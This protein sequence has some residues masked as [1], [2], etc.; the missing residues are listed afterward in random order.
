MGEEEL[1]MTDWSS[2]DNKLLDSSWYTTTEYHEVFKTLRDEDPIHWAQDEHY[3]RPYWV[4][5]RYDDV[6]DYLQNW[7]QLSSRWD[8]RVPKSPKRRTP[9]ER[10]AVGMDVSLARNDPP[11]HDLYRRPLN[12]HFSVPAINK[13]TQGVSDIVDECIADVAEKGE[14]DVV[15]TL[16]GELPVKV[17]LRWL[18]VPE[19][20]W[21]ML[22]EATWQWLAPADPNFVIDNDPV[23]TTLVGQTRLLEYCEELALERRRSPQDDF[24][25]V[26][27]NMTIDGDRL[28]PHEMRSYLTN[29]IGGGLETTRNAASV[30]LWQ[31]LLNPDQRA[32]LLADPSLA[33]SAVEEVVRWVTP[34]KNRLRVA[35]DGFEWRDKFINRGDWV[36][37]FQAS[38]NKD[39]RVFDDPH[40]F[41]ITRDPSLHI[42]FGE[43]V[44]MCL[45][46]ALARLELALFFPRV[47]AAFPD[48]EP[49]GDPTW[50]ADNVTTGFTQFPVTFTP[51]PVPAK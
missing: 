5:T 32:L 39:E 13:L 43:G 11:V 28:S 47:L 48:M 14:C 33:N 19:E 24:A 3:G 31:F 2:I 49:A 42:G 18:G 30:G 27:G 41:D 40:R 22:R 44:H 16:A 29:I 12:K 21:P 51:R 35:N 15:E 34:G 50:I 1:T 4:V 17:I 8:T 23:K 46:R 26:I 6:K 20:D 45:G 37:A 38:A 10:Y 7:T 25:T 36:I 9:E